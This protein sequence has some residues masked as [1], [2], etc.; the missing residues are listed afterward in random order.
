MNDCSAL[1]CSELV[2]FLLTIASFFSLLA[3]SALDCSVLGRSAAVVRNSRIPHKSRKAA[4]TLFPPSIPAPLLL[5]PFKSEHDDEQLDAEVN[6]QLAVL[7][8]Q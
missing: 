8:N 7:M 3:A 4:Q 6:K 5:S 1:D 2:C